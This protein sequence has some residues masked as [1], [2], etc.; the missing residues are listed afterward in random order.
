MV[1]NPA[2]GDGMPLPFDIS[3]QLTRADVERI[4]V[5]AYQAGASDVFFQTG[6]PVRMR[7]HGRNLAATK[8]SL[9]PNEL[10]TVVDSTVRSTS[11]AVMSGTPA[12]YA[13]AVGLDRVRV[14]NWRVNATAC[15]VGARDHG[16]EVVFR[17]IPGVPPQIDEL[18]LPSGLRNAFKSHDGMRIVVGPTG[19]GKSTLLASQIRDMLETGRN[20]VI[21]TLEKPVEFTY[22]LVDADP[23][24]IISQSEVGRDVGTFADGV[25]NCLRRAPTDILIGEMRDRATIAAGILASQTG[26]RVWT[27]AHA[28]SVSATIYRL[29]NGFDSDDR[30]MRI[31][32]FV[33][34]LR[35]IVVQHLLPRL[36]GGRVPVREWL[37]VNDEMRERLLMAPRQEIH[38]VAQREVEARRQTMLDDVLRRLN[39][40]EIALSAAA[41]Y[42][43]SATRHEP[44]DSQPWSGIG[45]AESGNGW[46]S[47]FAKSAKG[48]GHRLSVVGAAR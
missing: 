48:L 47:A 17:A 4:L 36:S 19:S 7:V 3:P 37:E 11:G 41:P 40:K 28:G 32:E 35:V 15:A 18:E 9:T 44:A 23:S 6:Q 43:E 5:V 46:L 45:K 1:S 26:H 33:Q 21:R 29:V 13:D 16:M 27:T 38:L 34:N 42:L 25:A 12:D 2:S 30:E 14:V 20:H 8:R 22:D 24:N 39:N 10:A 31:V